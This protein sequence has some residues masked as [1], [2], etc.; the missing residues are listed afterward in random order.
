MPGASCWDSWLARLWLRILSVDSCTWPLVCLCFSLPQQNILDYTLPDSFPLSWNTGPSMPPL[1]AWK[2]LRSNMLLS[3]VL[4]LN[5]VSE[6]QARNGALT[7]YLALR[8]SWGPMALLLTLQPDLFC[9]WEGRW[10]LAQTGLPLRRG[11]GGRLE[12][13]KVELYVLVNLVSLSL[14]H[15]HRQTQKTYSASSCLQFWAVYCKKD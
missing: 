5:W 12:A 14:P 2:L 13:V 11:R 9:S 1:L 7:N 4:A 6:T 8:E 15:N 3:W 10:H